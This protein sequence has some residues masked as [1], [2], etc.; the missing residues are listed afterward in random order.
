MIAATFLG[1]LAASALLL[2]GLARLL[3]DGFLA[4]DITARSNHT[5]AARQIGGLAVV[6][7]AL[8]AVAVAFDIVDPQLG[9]GIF[10]GATVLLAI[11]YLD[12]R[13]DV[14][15]IFKLAGQA[16]AALVFVAFL[17]DFRLL[18][19]ILP[20]A[21]ER[22][23]IAL[24][25]V[26]FINMVNFMDG[27]DL[28][29]VAGTG[30]PL[31]AVATFGIF[32]LIAAEPA[33]V[34][35]ATAGALFGFSPFNRPPA[36]IFLGDSGSLPV[37]FLA[38]VVVVLVAAADPLAALAPLAYFLVDSV[39]T[40]AK[41]SIRRE[42]IFTAHSAHAYQVARRAGWRVGAV[43]GAVAAVSIV[44]S[45]AAGAALASDAAYAGPVALASALAAARALALRFRR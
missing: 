10:G 27:L 17:G 6:P 42:A 22:A 36:R 37:G 21:A 19:H 26:W 40:L 16:A 3:P 45:L 18:P 32:G 41:R 31:A 14:R 38:G 33:L 39:T 7:S 43:S 12:D 4:P 8:F 24:F 2:F 23:F 34:A 13:R 25:I 20:L 44:S 11:G 28:M 1:A 15:A 9:I 29:V 35:A 5:G 30:V